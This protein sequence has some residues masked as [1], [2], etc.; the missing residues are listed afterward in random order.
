MERGTWDTKGFRNPENEDGTKRDWAEKAWN[1][2]DLGE[3]QA[4]G[5]E[6]G[7]AERIAAVEVAAVQAIVVD[8]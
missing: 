4:L 8:W 2:T 3:T 7:L 1:E 5:L 6:F